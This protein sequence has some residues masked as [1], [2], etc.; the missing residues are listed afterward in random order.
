MVLVAVGDGD[1]LAEAVVPA[2]VENG[3]KWLVVEQDS[4]T[5]GTPIENMEKSLKCIKAK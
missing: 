1:V 2:A 3:A 4:H 5:F